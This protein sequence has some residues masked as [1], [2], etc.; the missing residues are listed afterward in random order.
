MFSSMDPIMDKVFA[1]FCYCNRERKV[2][3]SRGPA[4][5]FWGLEGAP[6]LRAPA[7]PPAEPVR[8]LRDA[9]VAHPARPEQSPRPG[10]DGFL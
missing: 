3:R 7:E 5:L 1:T 9:R 10:T 8:D 2:E 6:A 4:R